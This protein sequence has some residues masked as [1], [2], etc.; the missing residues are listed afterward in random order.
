VTH[1]WHLLDPLLSASEADDMQRLCERYGR[2]RMYS[3]EA[4]EVEIGEGLLQRHDAV[5]NFLA[6]GGRHG[7]GEPVD[8]LAART[9]YFRESYAYGD[10]I[11][12]DGIERFLNHDAFV[13]AARAIHGRPVIEPAIVYANILVPGQELAVHTDVPEFRG[14]N[15]TRYPHWL[16]V[17]MH[18]S[19]LFAEW[20]MPI[21]TA[22]SWFSACRGG[23]FVFWPDG[24]GGRPVTLPAKRNTAIVLDTDSVFHGVDP[25]AAS[26]PMP[27]LRPGMELV[28]EG[29]GRW[30]VRAG[31][32]CVATWRSDELRFSVSWKAYCFADDA[33]R[34]SWREHTDDLELPFIL[35]RLV[36]DLRIRGRLGR[37]LPD[38]TGLAFALIDEY[39]RFPR[40]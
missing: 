2:Y 1:A 31:A 13:A 12:V 29:D 39:V 6:T 37:Q 3:Q 19:G 30:T 8:A 27:P 7:R 25:V 5:G 20:R 11:M 15:R 4:A 32:E 24:A 17:V 10:R 38:D 34:R 18:H 36:E 23:E 16:M 33:E 35:G 28:F 21:V 14:A 22:V 9:N 40:A 26:G